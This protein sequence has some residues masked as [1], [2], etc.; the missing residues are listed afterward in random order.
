MNFRKLGNKIGNE[1]CKYLSDVLKVN[2]SLQKLNLGS[3]LEN[4]PSYF[5]S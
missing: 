2:N 5:V 1:G 4:I 3:N